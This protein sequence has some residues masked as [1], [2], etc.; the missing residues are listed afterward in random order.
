MTATLIE[1]DR[2]MHDVSGEYLEMVQE[3]L[4]RNL[5]GVNK[6]VRCRSLPQLIDTQ[7][8]LFRGNLELTLSNGRRPAEASPRLADNTTRTLT[9]QAGKG[10]K[11]AA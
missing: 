6:L 2:E 4:Q 8:A 11:R 5:D 9:A 1:L 7:G 3:R 10:T